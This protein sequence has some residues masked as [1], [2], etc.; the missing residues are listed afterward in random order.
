MGTRITLVCEGKDSL[1][2]VIGI[3]LDKISSSR[4]PN[5]FF[6]VRYIRLFIDASACLSVTSACL[7]MHQTWQE[8]ISDGGL[9]MS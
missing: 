2:F 7:S 1:C 9:R 5:A 4:L 6:F 3:A 8:Y